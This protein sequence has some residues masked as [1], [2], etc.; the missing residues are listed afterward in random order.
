M[1]SLISHTLVC[2]NWWLLRMAHTHLAQLNKIS[3][4][5]KC[6]YHFPDVILQ[7]SSSAHFDNIKTKVSLFNY[8]LTIVLNKKCFKVKTQKLLALNEMV[9]KKH[10]VTIFCCWCLTCCSFLWLSINSL[11]EVINSSWLC[12][13]KP[14]NSLKVKR[15]QLNFQLDK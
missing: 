10:K 15:A 7:Q 2:R 3:Q 9:I 1:L 12:G 5:V 13:I 6:Q 8:H 11:I 14:T 4:I